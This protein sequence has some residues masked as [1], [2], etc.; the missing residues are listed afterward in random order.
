MKKWGIACLVL[1]WGLVMVGLAQAGPGTVQIVTKGDISMRLGAQVRF[2]PT[3]ENDR[4][5]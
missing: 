4:D 2:I 3:W 1:V 5:F